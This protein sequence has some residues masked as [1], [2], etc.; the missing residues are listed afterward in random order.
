MH[1]TSCSQKFVTKSDASLHLHNKKAELHDYSDQ[2]TSLHIEI[3]WIV[4]VHLLA[5][6]T[7]CESRLPKRKGDRSRDVHTLEKRNARILINSKLV[8]CSSNIN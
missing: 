7:Q 2:E 1:R 5:W 3:R 6:Q 4:P 8:D